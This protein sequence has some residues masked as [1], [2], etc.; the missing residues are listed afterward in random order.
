[1]RAVLRRVG[2]YSAAS[3]PGGVVTFGEIVIDNGRREVAIGGRLVKLTRKE[4]DLL[5]LLAE[6]PGTTFTRTRLLEEV[7]DF[8]WDGDTA[9]VTVHVRRLREKIEANPSEPRHLLTVWGVGYR[10]EP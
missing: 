5:S 6:H 3:A 10:F 4:F 2:G 1:V 9:T 7:W 8:A